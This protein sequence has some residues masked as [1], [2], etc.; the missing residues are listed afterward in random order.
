MLPTPPQN[1]P[2]SPF[3]CFV[4]L[5]LLST[6]WKPLQR[7]S[8]A[9]IFLSLRVESYHRELQSLCSLHLPSFLISMAVSSLLF[10]CPHEHYPHRHPPKPFSARKLRARRVRS[11][12]RPPEDYRFS[13]ADKLRRSPNGSIIFAINLIK[14]I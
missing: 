10:H 13:W 11:Q 1:R 3:A 4:A 6:R 7:T 12:I 2:I 14:K 9:T 5:L 8:K